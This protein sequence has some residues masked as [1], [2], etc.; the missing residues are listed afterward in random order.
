MFTG[1]IQAVGKVES[2][3][4]LQGD[5][6]LAINIGGLKNNLEVGDSIAVNGVCLTV[7]DKTKA[8]FITDVSTETLSLTMLG[9]L[10]RGGSRQS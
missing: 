5:V 3:E 8:G 7:T 9:K 2:L 10:Q 6:R 4:K 1:I